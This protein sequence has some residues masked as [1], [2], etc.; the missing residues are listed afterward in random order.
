MFVK[1]VLF[2][3]GCVLASFILLPLLMIG[4]GLAL[5]S[6]A[7]FGEV[8]DFLIGNTDKSLDASTAREIAHR[9]CLGYDVRRRAAPVARS[10][11]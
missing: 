4:G 1:A 5:F 11:R 6:Y 3:I 7:V 8:A 10:K 2:P 9:M